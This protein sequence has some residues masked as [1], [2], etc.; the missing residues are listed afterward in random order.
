MATI[1]MILKG[2]F[3]RHL[4]HIVNSLYTFYR[5]YPKKKHAKYYRHWC[6][7]KA[8]GKTVKFDVFGGKDK[9]INKFSDSYSDWIINS[10]GVYRFRRGQLILY[11][12]KDWLGEERSIED[13]LAGTPEKE[14]NPDDFVYM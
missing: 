14:L 7:V 12:G 1:V 13:D 10:G 5:I 3:F 11:Y 8:D 4:R 9:R 6:E 2:E